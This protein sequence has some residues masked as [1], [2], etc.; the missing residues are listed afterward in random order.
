[1]KVMSFI[2]INFVKKIINMKKFLL[3]F[4]TVASLCFSVSA[5]DFK[6]PAASPSQKIEQQ[7]SISHIKL[8]YSRPSVKGRKIFGDL[9]PY[10]KLWRTGANAA[11]K[12]TF[13]EDVKINGQLIPAGTY[14]LYTIPGKDN[15]EVI[16]NKS[17]ENW[18]NT[19]FNEA[20]NVIQFTVKPTT[21]K[22]L[23][24]TFTID[25]TNITTNAAT[26][27]I[28][29][30]YTKV[31]FNVTA[32]NRDKIISY[33]ETELKGSKPPYAQAANYY[34]E[35]NYK[36]DQALT[37]VDKALNENPNAFW[38]HWLKARIYHKMGDTT[39]AIASAQKAYEISK[40]TD[41]EEEYKNNYENMKKG[42]K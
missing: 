13:G 5:Q 23:Q 38:L 15:W 34:L 26:I 33:L 29:W 20:E 21:L 24:E 14:S 37:Y 8:D 27:N 12:I 10:G 6:M 42:M 30:E 35:Q 41:Y 39:N 32:D 2:F 7:F 4:I 1:M 25:V 16:I 19:G 31:S 17:L 28:S 18:G 3:S 9:V 11:S 40:G 36:L 22:D